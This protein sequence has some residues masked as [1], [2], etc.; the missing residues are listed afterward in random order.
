MHADDKTWGVIT[1]EEKVRRMTEQ[2]DAAMWVIEQNAKRAKE[3]VVD[4]QRLQ[5][6]LDNAV[7][8]GLS[9]STY[10]EIQGPISRKE[11]DGLMSDALNAKIE[12]DRIRVFLESGGVEGGGCGG[13]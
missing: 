13:N 7:L 2:R 9:L 12:R 11:L 8:L 5:F 6:V 10:H 4:A 3:L 1:A